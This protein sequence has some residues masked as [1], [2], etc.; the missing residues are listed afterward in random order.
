MYGNKL[1]TWDTFD[2][3]VDE[4]ERVIAFEWL[5]SKFDEIDGYVWKKN[6]DHDFG[7]YVSF[8]VD[9]PERFEYVDYCY[10]D[11]D[12]DCE[13]CELSYK[14]DKWIDLANVISSEYSKKFFSNK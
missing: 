13:D 4:K 5:E 10:D 14:K 3:P 6:N 12:D 8:E 1:G 2:A 7:T 9:L 11:C